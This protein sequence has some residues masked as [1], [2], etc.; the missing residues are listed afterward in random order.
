MNN[1]QKNQIIKIESLNMQYFF[2]S[3]IEQAHTLM[4]LTDEELEHIQIQ[5]IKIL[6]KQ[7]SYYTKDE[8]SSIKIETSKNILQSVF[9]CVSIYLKSLKDTNIML[10]TI[11]EKPVL[12]LYEKG[13]KLINIQIDDTKKLLTSI[14]Q[15]MIITDNIAY[16]DTIQSGIPMFFTEYNINFEAQESPGSIDYPLSNDK[17][18][19][20]GIEYLYTYLKKLSIE[21]NFC[22]NFPSTNISYLLLGYDE[23]YEDLLINIFEIVLKN[24]I[25]CILINTP[26]CSLNIKSLDREYLQQT[27]EKLTTDNL[28]KVIV[29]A[30]KQLYNKLNISDQSLQHHILD[31]TINLLP[32][33]NNALKHNSLETIFITSKENKYQPLFEIN[34]E[35]KLDDESLRKI[36]S[37][38]MECR[39]VSDKKLIIKRNIHSITD[40]VDVLEGYCIFE[41][42]FTEVFK[43]L[44]DIE[45]AMLF[46]KY[47]THLIDSNLHL[48]ENEKDWQDKFSYFLTTIDTNKHI[49]ITELAMQLD[50]K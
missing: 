46:K 11:K 33:I 47:P 21:N 26:L 41:D 50:F 42:E 17:L 29:G 12:T 2:Q 23:H 38:I 5:C 18:N 31:T 27:L 39:Y 9:Y 7:I 14:Q 8:S 20:V 43:S 16:N 4:L 49:I 24:A 32:S 1:I 36:I 15:D 45:L 22:R 13:I 19:L 40:L 44:S 25:G 3:F 34:E 30:C 35:K 28:C 48:T 37:E 6:T 10:N